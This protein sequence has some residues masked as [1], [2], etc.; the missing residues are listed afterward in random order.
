MNYWFMLNNYKFNF[1]SN[2]TP[3]IIHW[4]QDSGISLLSTL[5][6]WNLV[7][8]WYKIVFVSSTNTGIEQLIWITGKD[9]IQQIYYKSDI[10]KIDYN[11]SL[12]LKPWNKEL[13]KLVI[14][15]IEKE[16]K[17]ILF[18]KD[19]EINDF[20]SYKIFGKY[21]N[22]VICWNFDKC[23]FS[24]SITSWNKFKKIYF[25]VPLFDESILLPNLEKYESYY[26]WENEKWIIKTIFY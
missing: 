12:I 9:K 8:N 18:V 24:Q 17:Y 14:E 15:K 25:Q 22:S 5:I 6:A 16:N 11:K 10:N 13:L 19:I 2:I 1:D 3:C 21:K 23:P 26:R 20:G 7:K 4:N